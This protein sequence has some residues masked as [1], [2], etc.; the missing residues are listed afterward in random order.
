MHELLAVVLVT[1]DHDTFDGSQSTSTT[2]TGWTS[3]L[4]PPSPQ[5]ASGFQDR[6]MTQAEVDRIMRLLLD[7]EHLE[8]DAAD[9]F[10][11]LMDRASAWYEWKAA[12]KTTDRKGSAAPNAKILDMCNR[13]QDDVLRSV[14]PAVHQKFAA[15]GIEGQL[16]G[17]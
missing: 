3:G 5:Q 1:L 7:R 16:W 2:A 8:A 14:D 17:M 13:I 11:A 9:L 10:F 6:S 12:A 15:E 4:V